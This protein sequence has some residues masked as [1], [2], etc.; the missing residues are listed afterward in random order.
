MQSGHPAMGA[1]DSDRQLN[2]AAAAALD[3]EH[4]SMGLFR[5]EMML[6]HTAGVADQ[7]IGRGEGGTRIR[8][9]AALRGVFR[10][11][12]LRFK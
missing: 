2:S 8:A 9:L 1:G 10:A 12:E 5:N 7:C 11:N 4:S 3:E 6:M